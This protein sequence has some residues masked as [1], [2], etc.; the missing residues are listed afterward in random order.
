MQLTGVVIERAIAQGSKS[1][2]QKAIVLKTDNGDFVLRKNGENPFE[3]SSLRDYVGKQVRV[4]GN[5]VDYL[6]FA[7]NIEVR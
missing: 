5:A 6:F 7:D 2:Q 4:T 3:S 1:E